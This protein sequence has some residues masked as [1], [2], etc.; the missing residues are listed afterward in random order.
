MSSRP[1]EAALQNRALLA[2]EKGAHGKAARG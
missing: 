1:P 2:F